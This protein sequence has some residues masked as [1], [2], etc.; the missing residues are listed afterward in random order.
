MR[1]SNEINPPPLQTMIRSSILTKHN[2]S[3]YKEYAIDCL[4]IRDFKE[5]VVGKSRL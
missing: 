4:K 1:F 5:T 3:K 2:S